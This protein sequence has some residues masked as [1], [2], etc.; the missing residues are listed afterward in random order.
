MNNKKG[1]IQIENKTIIRD[2]FRKDTFIRA[3]RILACSLD[4]NT[5]IYLQEL[6][7]YE[8]YIENHG[9]LENNMFYHTIQDIWIAT[10]LN[11]YEQRKARNQLVKLNLIKTKLKGVPAKLHY[12]CNH[13]EIVEFREI[14][15]EALNDE[16]ENTKNNKKYRPSNQKVLQLGLKKLNDLSSYQTA[17]QLGSKRFDINKLNNKLNRTLSPSKEVDKV[18]GDAPVSIK[19]VDPGKKKEFK[20]E[21]K[22]IP[23]K[24]KEDKP[25]IDWPAYLEKM[26]ND[27][28]PNIRLIARFFKK[29]KISFSTTSQVSTAI[30]RHSRASQKLISFSDKD[31]EWAA[32]YCKNK[33]EPEGIDWTLETMLKALTSGNR[34]SDGS[35]NKTIVNKIK[36]DR[37][38]TNTKAFTLEI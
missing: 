38:Y 8:E 30:S 17:L 9:L 33:W 12:S 22:N 34:N 26:F 20:K 15:K 2:L 29:K 13:N 7:S 23:T 31:L 16:I 14:M 28:R 36:E 6:V 32:T 21:N 10:G 35:S 24:A 19:N 4:P 25:I 37:D 11:D 1:V 27:S 5:A 18:S 3:D